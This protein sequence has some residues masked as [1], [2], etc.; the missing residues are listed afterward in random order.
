MSTKKSLFRPQVVAHRRANW[1]GPVLL[2]QPLHFAL[3]ATVSLIIALLIVGYLVFGEYTKKARVNGYLTPDQ[4]V[5]KLFAPQPG[6]LL[7]LRVHEG[8]A[9]NR[10]D[11]LLVISGERATPS[12]RETQATVSREL[13]LRKASL[14]DDAAQQQQRARQQRIELQSRI[15]SMHGELDQLDREQATQRSRVQLANATSERYRE[16]KAAKFVSDLQFQQRTDELL[17]QQG[18]LQAL[19]RSSLVLQRDIKAAEGEL[20]DLPLKTQA[21]VAGIERNILEL[22]QQLA[23]SESRR[24]VAIVAPESGVATAIL[25]EAGQAV[26]TSMPLVSIIPKDAHLEA[27]LF[28]PSRAIGFIEPGRTVLLRYQAYPYQKFG[29]YEGTVKSISKSPINPVDVQLPMP[30]AEPLYRIT[31]A[32]ASQSAIAYGQ[33]QSLQA[34]MQVEADVLL[35]RRRLIEWLFEPLYSLTGR[36]RQRP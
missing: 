34:G 2:I 11:L 18:R 29:Q 25:A 7:E 33:P 19:E 5:L 24:R 3:L 15:A 26:T 4:G 17:D 20:L 10:G 22:D 32:L 1:L 9:V 13:T 6:T 35:D 14:R 27:R 21:T 8:Q 30:G 31:V 23:E 12:Q 28:A 36:V 16:L